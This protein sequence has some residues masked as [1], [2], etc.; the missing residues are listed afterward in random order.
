MTTNVGSPA[1]GIAVKAEQN[2]L[3]DRF[4]TAVKDCDVER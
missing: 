3:A 2:V 4:K 1:V